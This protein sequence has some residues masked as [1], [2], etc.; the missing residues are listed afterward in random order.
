[1]VTN[2]FRTCAR[3]LTVSWA[4]FW[5]YFLVGSVLSDG[6][7]L[8][9][10]VLVCTIGTSFFLSNCALVWLFERAGSLVMAT[11]GV[12]LTI[13][14]FTF[15]HNSSQTQTFLLLTLCLP[16]LA[17]GLMLMKT[18]PRSQGRAT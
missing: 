1:M 10:K 12:I 5:A 15:L 3:A 9:A 14:N 7:S 4:G 11:E 13:L 8:G 16:P 2:T 17:V 18:S 6:G